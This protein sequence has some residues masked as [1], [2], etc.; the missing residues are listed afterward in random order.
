[1][2]RWRASLGYLQA[3]EGEP[4]R[5]KFSALAARQSFRRQVRLLAA[6]QL[7]SLAE[8]RVAA[9]AA[10]VTAT[11]LRRGLHLRD[12]TRR[13]SLRG[14]RLHSRRCWRRRSLRRAAGLRP[15]SE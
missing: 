12:S 14:R 5:S 4:E 13:H 11:L 7:L 8:L 9:F 15:C 1:M 6:Q 2:A 3:T 10:L